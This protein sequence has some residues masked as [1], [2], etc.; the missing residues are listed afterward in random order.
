MATP[1]ALELAEIVP[2]VAPVH[3]VPDNTQVTP[4][5]AAS[6]V[7]VAVMPCVWPT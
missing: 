5:F 3:P 4:W 7:T 6:L 1:E 2:H